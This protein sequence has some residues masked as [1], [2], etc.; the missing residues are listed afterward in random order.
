MRVPNARKFWRHL[1]IYRD[2]RGLLSNCG[3]IGTFFARE[4]VQISMDKAHKSKYSMYLE[5]QNKIFS[6]HDINIMCA[7]R[8]VCGCAIYSWAWWWL[9][10]RSLFQAGESFNILIFQNSPNYDLFILNSIK[11]LIISDLYDFVLN[12]RELT[13]KVLNCNRNNTNN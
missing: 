3:W 11:D 8:L 2:D 9:R 4:G 1:D 7:L 12:E 6:L 10:G 5:A 13:N